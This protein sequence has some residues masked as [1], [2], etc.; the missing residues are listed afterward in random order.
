MLSRFPFSAREAAGYFAK[1]HMLAQDVRA[2][3][4]P[5]AHYPIIIVRGMG[6]CPH[7]YH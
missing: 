6:A 7:V 2:A 4:A 5:S 3:H 1:E